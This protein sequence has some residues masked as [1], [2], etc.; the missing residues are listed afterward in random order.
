MG[1]G[2]LTAEFRR[3]TSPREQGTFR[4]VRWEASKSLQTCT[5]FADLHIGPVQQW[6]RA[7]TWD[8]CHVV[9]SYD[10]GSLPLSRRRQ[11]PGAGRWS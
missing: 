3:P 8:V 6:G 2:E 10:V 7:P 11:S 5:S 9:E 4:D 1:I